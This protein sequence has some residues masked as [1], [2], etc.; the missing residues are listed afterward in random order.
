ME[1]LA[2]FHIHSRFSRATSRELNLEN[3]HASALLKGLSVIGTGDFTHPGWLQ[4][5]EEK[6]EPAEEGL[7]RLRKELAGPVQ[8][9][10]PSS[11]RGDV[12]FVLTT[13]ISSIYKKGGQVRKVHNL[14]FVPSLDAGRRLAGR[15]E[16]VGNIASDGRPILGLDSKDLLSLVLEISPDA[17][18]V[19][20]HIWTPWFSVLGSKS[21]FDSILE[22]F[23]DLSAEIFALETG[24]SADPA[25]CGRLTA[26]DRYSLISNSD[27]H[28]PDKLG[29]EANV[30]SCDLSFFSLRDSL[31]DRKRKGF[32]GTIEFFPEQGKYHLDG[33]RKCRCRME[34]GETLLRR[35]LCRVCGKEVTVG[36]MHRVEALA[37]RPDGERPPDALPY[38]RLISLSEVL[39]EARKLGPQAG[40]VQKACRSLVERLGPELMILRRSPLEDIERAAGPLAAEGIRRMRQAEVHLEAGYDGEFGTVRLFREGERERISGQMFF[41]GLPCPK[42]DRLPEPPA[43]S[44]PQ[45]ERGEDAPGVEAAWG[46]LFSSKRLSA[47]SSELLESLNPEQQEA[48]LWSGSPLLIVAGPGTGKTMTLT[49]RIAYLIEEAGIPADRILA[50]TFTL[51]AAREM[52][53]RLRSLLQTSAGGATVCV[54]TFHALGA[55]L[56]RGAG[57]AVGVPENFLVLDS[58]DQEIL[59]RRALPKLTQRE[60]AVL[61]ERISLEKRGLRY[62]EDGEREFE[63]PDFFRAYLAYQQAL[64]QSRALD[65]D[66]LVSLT[67]RAMSRSPGFHEKVQGQ[68]EAVCVDEY[69]DVNLAQYRFLRLLADSRQE[70]C[71][72]GDPDQA[73][74]GF[75]G[76]SPEYFRQFERDWPHG[77]VVRLVRNYRS[78]EAILSSSCKMLSGGSRKRRQESLVP[79]IGAGPPIHLAEL[80]TEKAEAILVA[81]TIERL[82][83]GTDSLS[84]YAGRVSSDERF[85]CRSFG[86]IAVL[87][88]L[89]AQAPI[90]EDALRHQ[91]IP[92]QSTTQVDRWQTLEGRTLINVL[93]WMRDPDDT[94]ALEQMRAGLGGRSRRLVEALNR[95]R[96]DA[97]LASRPMAERLAALQSVGVL[98]LEA[99]YGRE[100][101]EA[102]LRLA[103]L[104]PAADWDGLLRCIRL[105][106]EADLLEEKSEKVTLATLHASK[107][108]EFPVVFIVGCEEDLLPFRIGRE[109][110]DPEE[111]RRLF[112]VGM[113]RAR[114]LLY[115][116]HARSRL[117]FGERKPAA[118]SP[119]LK[120]LPKERIERIRWAG[121]DERK[122]GRR[123]D[124]Q[125]SL[126][127]L[128]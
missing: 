23:E 103:V 64:E 70:L 15:L 68:F 106:Q 44:A 14:I 31:R 26:L 47:W 50:V 127:K 92:Y 6:L 69:Q 121:A 102:L 58:R 4:E 82:M 45:A 39:G 124:L 119:F 116:C 79:M 21:G 107:G 120:D 32:I 88:R 81:Q 128:T 3:L 53:E 57:S 85:S 59:L 77:K 109:P 46:P 29:R 27:A 54:R 40:A 72:I 104:E 38:D 126:F 117:L 43:E 20:A 34:P 108:L 56:L 35:G 91:G 97:R 7:F 60:S 62:P 87:F 16:K 113:T 11:C 101:W 9:Q 5:I 111:E 123:K 118:A 12:R 125:P 75:R 18:L 55:E 33:H 110:S 42:R 96:A 94:L 8:R 37:D 1:F 48:V 122:K 86:E 22:C 13:E 76:A 99:S 19:P 30:F 90:L 73:I 66:D 95:Y 36:V 84:L 93:R 100:A 98:P 89:G 10:I 17:F 71:V 114:H 25:M 28:S 67:V 52:G 24:L 63:D 115:I 51:K 65:F 2:D 83:G 105:S 80:P 41:D 49:C 112:Y 78:T 74:Y 61:L